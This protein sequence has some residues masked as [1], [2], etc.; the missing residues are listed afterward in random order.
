M[1][2]WN[3]CSRETTKPKKTAATRDGRATTRSFRQ[4]EE[5]F[6]MLGAHNNNNGIINSFLVCLPLALT[7]WA[8][9]KRCSGVEESRFESPISSDQESICLEV[10]KTK[11]SDSWL[12]NT[13][14]K[15]T[16][17]KTNTT[18]TARFA[19]YCGSQ[20][21]NN[22]LDDDLRSESNWTTEST[23]GDWRSFVYLFVCLFGARHLTLGENERVNCVDE[24]EK[25]RIED[26]T[27]RD[28]TRWEK[29]ANEHQNN[30][31]SL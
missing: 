26:G 10:V 12:M 5:M 25:N 31:G 22:I 20:T 8:L 1:F 28:E 18:K 4:E 2:C 14:L 15:V 30:N 21:T 19:S 23:V 6:S 24:T 27:R 16:T 9:F 11:Q 13:T 7:C 17:T 29:W 3:K